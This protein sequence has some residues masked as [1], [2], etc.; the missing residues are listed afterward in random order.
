M[1]TGSLITILVLFTSKMKVWKFW[2]KLLLSESP[3]FGTILDN[4]LETE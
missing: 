2:Y 1:S 4:W 3:L